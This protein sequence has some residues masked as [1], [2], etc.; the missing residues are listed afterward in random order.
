MDT[1]RWL[2]E[3]VG[4]PWDALQIAEQGA[5]IENSA[6]LE[7]LH[8][9]GEIFTDAQMTHLLNESVFAPAYSLHPK[10][11]LNCCIWLRAHGAPWPAVLAC[12]MDDDDNGVPQACDWGPKAVVW[13]REQG[14]TAPLWSELTPAQQQQ[15]QQQIW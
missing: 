10:D 6:V 9:Q 1:L 11:D 2:R 13:A 7:Y 4:C 3:G 8:A 12:R 5:R 14:C 15:Q